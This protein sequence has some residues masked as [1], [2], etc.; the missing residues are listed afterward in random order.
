MLIERLYFGITET[1]QHELELLVLCLLPEQCSGVNC[2]KNVYIRGCSVGT[3]M[4][5]Y[6]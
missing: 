1:K 4:E 3:P 5:G 6:F 2:V